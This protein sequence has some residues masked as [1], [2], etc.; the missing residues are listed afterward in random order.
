MIILESFSFV[1]SFQK[2]KIT[3]S[4]I[5][6]SVNVF[7]TYEMILLLVTSV[8]VHW[9]LS[10]PCLFHNPLI[11]WHRWLLNDGGSFRRFYYA[12]Q[13]HNFPREKNTKSNIGENEDRWNDEVVVVVQKVSVL[14]LIL[15]SRLISFAFEGKWFL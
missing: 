3:M 12:L 15:N 14:K 11:R 13:F 10:S 5:T 7:K 4:L 2:A 1:W 6:S 9:I 8:D